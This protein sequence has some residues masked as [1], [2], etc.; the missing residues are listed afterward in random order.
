M[1]FYDVDF[2]ATTAGTTSGGGILSAQL[3]VPSG[4]VPVWVFLQGVTGSLQ[5]RY[6]DQVVYTNVGHTENF[7]MPTVGRQFDARGAFFQ[8]FGTGL[9]VA[10]AFTITVGCK[11]EDPRFQ[12]TCD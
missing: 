10:T 2:L 9:A 11:A 6:N 5:W 12:P 3:Q 7:A 1:G 4:H 8:F